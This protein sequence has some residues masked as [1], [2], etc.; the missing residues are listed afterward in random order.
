MLARIGRGDQALGLLNGELKK[1]DALSLRG[2]RASVLEALDRPADAEREVSA[3]IERAPKDQ[4][5]YRLLA[6]AREAQGNRVGA[7]HALEVCLA[8]TCSSPGKCGNQAFDVAAGRMLARIYL[9]D[10]AQPARVTELLEQ[11]GQN[12]QAP[13][14]DDHYLTALIARNNDSAELPSMAA[15]LERALHPQDPRRGWVRGRLTAAA[16]PA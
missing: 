15:Q 2:A 4:G 6:R 14:W 7:A 11:I 12:V 1:G 13:E 5:L 9:E 8:H 3:L 16:A 10:R